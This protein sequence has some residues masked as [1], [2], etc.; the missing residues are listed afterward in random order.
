MRPNRAKH[1]TSYDHDKPWNRQPCD[2]DARWRA[3]LA[4]RD[5]PG[6]RTLRGAQEALTTADKV[7]D[8]RTL[9]RWTS[10]FAWP[11]RC[12][13]FDR[14]LDD[15]RVAV[16]VDVLEES[17]RETA[18]RH[19]SIARDA[20]E[21][22]RSV[23]DSWLER[24]GR[25]ERLDGWSPNDV[26]GMLKDMITLERLVRGEATERVE[27]GIGFDLSRLSLDEIETMRAI[28]VKAGVVD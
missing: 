22:A 17:T 5:Q 7:F 11:E 21:A 16:L 24:L 1:P 3:F 13:A 28:E 15:A 2:T 26:R 10:A 20:I 8:M 25:G 19:A 6:V 12:A 23:V 27:H 14:Y 4:F 9:E 18:A